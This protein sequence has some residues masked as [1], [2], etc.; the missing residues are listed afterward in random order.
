MKNTKKNNQK[1]GKIG[2]I[3]NQVLGLKPKHEYDEP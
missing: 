3:V 1:A 2:Q